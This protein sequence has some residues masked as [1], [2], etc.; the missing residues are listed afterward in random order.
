VGGGVGLG[1]SISH[2]II[3][4]HKGQLKIKSETGKGSEFIIDLPINL[5]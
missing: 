1:M 4:K 2:G 3:E 5:T